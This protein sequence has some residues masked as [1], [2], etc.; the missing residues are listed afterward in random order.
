MSSRETP[1][2]EPDYS[3]VLYAIY[4][5]MLAGGMAKEKISELSIGALKKATEKGCLLRRES[6]GTLATTALV[7]DAWHRDRRYLDSDA[8]PRAVRLLGRPPSVEALVRGEG[9][10]RS[11][12]D[13]AR[14]LKILGFVIPCG[15]GLYRPTSNVALIS[16]LDPMVL[17]HV[18]HALTTL[19]ETIGHNLARR[20]EADCLIERF[21]EVPDLP[22]SEVV[23]FQRF[24]RIQSWAFLQVA[25]DWL[26][27]R[28]AKRAVRMSGAVVRAGVHV[29]AYLNPALQRLPMRKTVNPVAS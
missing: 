17:Q 12:S 24:T 13:L 10:R 14:R 16:A 9:V 5:F 11:A 8:R 25:N 27:S 19:L 6:T 2:Q 28:R 26:E 23:A 15:R 1:T 4:G 7:L 18:A 3:H 29:H 22:A 21:A 20:R